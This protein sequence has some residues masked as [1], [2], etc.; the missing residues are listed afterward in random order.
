MKI[1]KTKILNI[2]S[3]VLVMLA[4]CSV[5]LSING[6][7]LAKE[8]DV[9]TS[10]YGYGEYV[11][12]VK[13]I[14]YNGV[15]DEDSVTFYYLPVY[16]EITEDEDTGKYYVD[17]DYEADD[18][19]EQSDGEVAKIIINV[20]DENGNLVEG[21]SPITVTPPTTKVELPM[22]AYNLP[23]GTYTIKVAA[24][25]ADNNELYKP[26]V[27]QFY[28]ETVEVPNTGSVFKNLNISK[29]DY[30]VTGLLIFF[31]FGIVGFGIIA[32]GNRKN[33]RK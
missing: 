1:I 8:I 13:G 4:M 26:Y 19:T 21:L 28:Y 10:D 27:F 14:G 11:I 24:Y 2:I 15:Y 7:A 18:G 6:N 23:T 33:N 16:A 32:R 30:L 20:Y 25:D 5:V 3:L 9:R 31:I 29:E 12:H 22:A 17:L